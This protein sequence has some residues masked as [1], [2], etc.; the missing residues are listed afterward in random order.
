MEIK[1]VVSN[2]LLECRLGKVD[3][4]LAWVLELLELML[5]LGCYVLDH[6]QLLHT[7][8]SLAGFM[9]E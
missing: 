6:P 5:H 7:A 3:E 2:G 9:H 1:N 4:P 8:D